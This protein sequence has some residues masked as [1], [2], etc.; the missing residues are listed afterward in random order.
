MFY[1]IGAK[2]A[3]HPS[4]PQCIDIAQYIQQRPNTIYRIGDDVYYVGCPRLRIASTN[5]YRDTFVLT[6]IL[7]MARPPA[8]DQETV[9]NVQQALRP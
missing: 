2:L 7:T 3:H 9:A 4:L 8:P 5:I 1:K 6:P